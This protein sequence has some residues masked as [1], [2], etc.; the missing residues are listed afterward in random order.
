MSVE[1]SMF[2]TSAGQARYFA[3]YDEM[4]SQWP[5]PIESFSVPTRY[6]STHINACG[7]KG[8]APLVLLPGAAVSSTMWYQNVEALSRSHRVFALDIIG[9]MGKSVL[10]YPDL[11]TVDFGIWL[12]D[13]YAALSLEHANIVGLSYGGLIA[14]RLASSTPARVSKLVLL[15][16]AGL[17]PFPVIFLF[18]MAAGFLPLPVR[19]K[20]K[21]MLG[22]DSPE[23]VPVIKQMMTRTNFR[24]QMPQNYVIK[25]EELRNIAAETLLLFGE[26]DVVYKAGKA[27]ERAENLIPNIEADIFPEAGHTLP[28]D[29]PEI[30][31]ERILEFLE[32]EFSKDT[33]PWPKP[34]I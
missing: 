9:D 8:A 14:M 28:L 10:T 11:K 1:L 31:N 2:R 4:P 12:G 30:V 19:V 5:V 17:L 15:D 33:H 25:D 24:Y 6:G 23:M 22:I 3:A 18:R 13:V 29:R 32:I 21:L 34:A 16:P 27:I 20:L 26:H 7:P